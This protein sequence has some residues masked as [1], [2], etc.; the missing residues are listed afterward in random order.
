MSAQD[1]ADEA[2]RK[3]GAHDHVSEPRM[4]VQHFGVTPSEA[5]KLAHEWA[6]KAKDPKGRKVR[7]DG[8]CLAAGVVSVPENFPHDKWPEYRDEIIKHLQKRYGERLKSVV[9]HLD[10]KC[11]HI[12]FYLV[13]LSDESFGSVHPGVAAARASAARGERKGMQNSAYKKAMIAWQEDIYTVSQ[14]FGLARIGPRRRRL[15]RD[16]WKAEQRAL[17]AHAALNISDKPIGL[18]MGRINQIIAKQV[19]QHRAGLLG[20]GRALYTEE[21]LIKA[22]REAALYG[23]QHVKQRLDVLDAVILHSSKIEA[24]EARLIKLAEEEV[25]LGIRIAEAN[26]KVKAVDKEALERMRM[27]LLK[28]E[29]AE[30]MAQQAE[31]WTKLTVIEME[32]RM[33][34]VLSPILATLAAIIRDPNAIKSQL[35]ADVAITALQELRPLAMDIQ[36]ALYP[37]VKAANKTNKVKYALGLEPD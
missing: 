11:P 7:I 32:A 18:S 19:V 31:S 22:A 28:A 13:P 30:D 1:I 12:H 36:Q 35:E 26:D 2:E 23:A 5:V 10:E 20:K 37:A 14:S 9:E 25:T 8:L 6:A 29:Q 33:K 4:P 24:A 21:Q 17:S 16:E 3:P 15:S 27:A 34:K